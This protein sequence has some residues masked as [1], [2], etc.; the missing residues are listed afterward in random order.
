VRRFKPNDAKEFKW[1]FMRGEPGQEWE[2]GA[3]PVQPL[4]S[5][6]S[7]GYLHGVCIPTILKDMGLRN[8]KNNHEWMYKKLQTEYG[9][10]DIHVGK[11]DK[12][13][14]VPKSGSD[15]SQE[16]MSAVIEG[17]IQFYGEFLDGVMPPPDKTKSMG[18]K[19]R[20][21]KKDGQEQTPKG[22]T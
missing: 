1:L 20:R 11:N 18:G 15:Y 10:C 13:L 8:S 3:R 9:P 17:A 12:E 16:E 2:V 14:L 5:E 7:Q 4:Y 6:E 21:K 22:N 19:K